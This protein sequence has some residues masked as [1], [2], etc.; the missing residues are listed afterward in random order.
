MFFLVLTD[1]NDKEKK[2]IFSGFH[3]SLFGFFISSLRLF[4][5]SLAILQLFIDKNI[6]AVDILLINY[7]EL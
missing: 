2:R 5:L 6:S 7:S 1:I 4:R 3:I